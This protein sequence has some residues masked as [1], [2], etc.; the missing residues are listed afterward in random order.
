MDV[1][2]QLDQSYPGGNPV[3][4]AVYGVRLGLETAYVGAVGTDSYG[5]V[6]IEAINSKGVDTS[7][8]KVLEGNTA[9]TQ[10][11]LENGNRIFGDYDEGVLAQFKLSQSDFD[12]IQTFDLFVSGL[13]GM[14]E[15]DLSKVKALGLK[16]AFDFAT[17]WDSPV[18]AVAIPSVDYAFFASD[19][20]FTESM[21]TFMKD[22]QAKGP[23][24]VVVTLGSRG[25]V[26][27]D[28]TKFY[29]YG[30]VACDVIDTMGAGDSYI[31]GFLKGILEGEPIEACMAIGAKTSSETIAYMGAW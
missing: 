6:M 16:V 22:M 10:V 9:I 19:E 23:Q 4:V 14:V 5:Q 30:I 20:A 15:H 12:F 3:N 31:A 13:W 8:I 21:A 1:Y 25:S 24:L 29:H 28:G 26:A 11:T 7:H 2:H 18:V 17:K 27:Y